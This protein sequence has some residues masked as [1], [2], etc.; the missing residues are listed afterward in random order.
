MPPGKA[1][2]KPLNAI[3]LRAS[4]EVLSVAQRQ[5]GIYFS[6]MLEKPGSEKLQDGGGGGGQQLCA[7]SQK[8]GD[9]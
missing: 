3:G 2:G 1:L 5:G 9:A 4:E 8:D 6:P 7:P